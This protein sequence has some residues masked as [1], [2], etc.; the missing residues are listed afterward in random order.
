MSV[1]EQIRRMW[2]RKFDAPMTFVRPRSVDQMG[3]LGKDRPV[4]RTA[5]A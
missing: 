5:S 3:R 4:S 2:A 1:V